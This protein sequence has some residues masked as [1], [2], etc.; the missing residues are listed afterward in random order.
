MTPKFDD[1]RETFM[2]IA[3]KPATISVSN[4]VTGAVIG[5]IEKTTRAEVEAAV[6]R[7]RTAQRIWQQM[8]VQE[9]CKL[10]RQFEKLLWENQ[11]EAMDIIRAETGKNDTSAFFEVVILANLVSWLFHNAP[12]LLAPRRRPPTFPIIQSA[13]VYYKPRGVVGFIT[14]WNYPLMLAYVD[15][16]PALAAGNAVVIKPSE[17]TPFSALYIRDLLHQVGIPPEVVQVVTGD[18]ETGAA[19][20]DYVDYISFTGSTASGKKV[21][22]KAAE[23]LIPYSLELGGK[24]AMLVL[25]DADL[26]LAATGALT[27]ALENAGQMC[28]SIER[29]Y[30]EDEV[31][32]KFVEKIRHYAEQFKLSAAQGFEVNMGSLT[33]ERE[34]QRAERH[35]ED[36][37]SKGATLV[38]GGK[39]RPDLGALFYE[40]AVLANVHHG[41][42]VMN[43]ETFG[44]VIPVMRVKNE[45][46][47]VALANSSQY[48]LS[49]AVFTRN[50]ALGEHLA[51][52]LDTG[53]V[54][55]NRT[56][57]VPGAHDLPWGGQKNSGVGRRGGPEGLLRFVSTQSVV[58]D[59]PFAARPS[60]TMLDSVVYSLVKLMHTVRRYVPFV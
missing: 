60:I 24:N 5:E 18:G 23:R 30:V 41:M 6:K 22:V 37:L 3:D 52:Q 19:L 7:A 25:R 48:G 4:P 36:A 49:G 42:D 15:A 29:V 59:R 45:A 27:G 50:V 35:V 12:R 38:F 56:T 53:D 43:E 46:E 44:P 47:A 33:H 31:Y 39:R 55:V 40:P 54:S 28:I 13:K 2:V 20:V 21:A 10:L 57:V 14:P 34:L 32:D 17:I 1:L 9:R 16:L 26:D 51:T 8:G 11:R 58:V